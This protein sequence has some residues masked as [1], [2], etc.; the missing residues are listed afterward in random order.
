MLGT[1]GTAG[2]S[3]IIRVALIGA[4]LLASTRKLQAGA[5]AA[6]STIPLVNL[7][8]EATFYV[9]KTAYYADYRIMEVPD[10]AARI[11]FMNR[12]FASRDTPDG[13]G[14]A[15][16][17]LMGDALGGTYGRN[18][19]VLRAA[20]QTLGRGRPGRDASRHERGAAAA[21]RPV[22]RV[23]PP[24]ASAG[25]ERGDGSGGARSPHCVRQ[26]G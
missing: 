15:D 16:V 26:C 24:A 8:Q 14:L 7:W 6:A 17:E 22:P 23:L 4:A 2:A 12:Q 1:I 3:I 9:A 20:G 10:E 19:L 25:L 13:E 18:V 21:T 11:Q 5:R